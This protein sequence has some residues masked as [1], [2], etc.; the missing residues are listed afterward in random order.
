MILIR[1]LYG[2]NEL[3]SKKE[4]ETAQEHVFGRVFN[5]FYGFGMILIWF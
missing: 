4:T 5:G 1:F 3:A 2:S